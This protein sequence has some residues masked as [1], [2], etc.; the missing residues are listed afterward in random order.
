MA[1]WLELYVPLVAWF[2]AVFWD[3][4]LFEKSLEVVNRG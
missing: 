2:Y 4:I 1:E 3:F